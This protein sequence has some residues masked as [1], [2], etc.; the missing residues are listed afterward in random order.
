[1]LLNYKVD[2]FSRGPRILSQ[3]NYYRFNVLHINFMTPE[4]VFL[5]KMS[6][7]GT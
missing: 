6:G 5:V 1:M 7:D 3:F 4:N 2:L